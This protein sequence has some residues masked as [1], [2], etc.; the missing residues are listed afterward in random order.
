MIQITAFNAGCYFAVENTICLYEV[1]GSL[2]D[3]HQRR[4]NAKPMR[5]KKHSGLQ[6]V[7]GPDQRGAPTDLN[8]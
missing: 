7:E 5:K 8:V 1:V 4:I 2:R 6:A 3:S